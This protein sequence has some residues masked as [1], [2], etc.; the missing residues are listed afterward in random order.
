MSVIEEREMS[1]PP[2]TNKYSQFDTEINS[3]HL[4]R[5]IRRYA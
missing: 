5:I 4:S 1:E 2:S 3:E